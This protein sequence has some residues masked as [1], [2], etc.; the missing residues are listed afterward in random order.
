MLNPSGSKEDRASLLVRGAAKAL[1]TKRAFL[2]ACCLVALVVWAFLPVLKSRF[3]IYDDAEYVTSNSNVQ[4]GLSWATLGWAFTSNEAANW[5]P[6]TWPSHSLDCQIY[7]LQP[8]GHHLTSLLLHAANSLLVF[9]LFRNLT[10]TVGRSFFVAALFGLHPI[11]VQSVAWIAERK[12]VLST[13]FFLLTLLVYAR[14]AHSRITTNSGVINQTPTR[15]LHNS[16]LPAYLLA[17]VFFALGLLSKQMLVTTPFV[18]LL[19]DY[20]PLKRIPGPLAVAANPSAAKPI[21]Q[22][23]NLVRL[24]IEKTPFFLLSATASAVVYLIQNQQGAVMQ[25]LPF[26]LRLENALI[27]TS[28]ILA[29]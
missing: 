25:R 20:W 19:L 8:W 17:V 16:S 5:H 3:L 6:L 24:T 12:D 27:C 1:K 7:A 23:V 2:A 4:A 9:L 10:G 13:F 11:H 26:H 14:Y 21:V 15:Q 18:L 29:N 28:V 22:R